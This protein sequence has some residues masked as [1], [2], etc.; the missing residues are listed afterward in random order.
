[1]VGIGIIVGFRSD[2]EREWVGVALALASGLAYAVVV[3]GMR[4]LRGLDPVWLSAVNNL[5]GAIA[6]FLWMTITQGPPVMPTLPQTL[7]LTAFGV[8]QMAIPYFLF[9]RGLRVVSAAEAGLLALIEPI[10]NPV[11]VFLVMHERPGLPTLV[12]G[13]LLLSGVTIRY[14]TFPWRRPPAA[15]SGR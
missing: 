14:V 6:L 7:A 10:L 13:L 1:M 4:G 15:D 12:G 9:A 2:G 5:S 11:W 8:I 3:I